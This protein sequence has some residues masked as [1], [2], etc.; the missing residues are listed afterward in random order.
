MKRV[1][2]N[3]DRCSFAFFDEK[4]DDWKVEP[5]VFE[6]LIGSSSRDIR[7]KTVCEIK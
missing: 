6:L 7:R 1:A 3:L 5:G 4:S 2:L